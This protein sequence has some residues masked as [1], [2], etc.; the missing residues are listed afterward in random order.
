M[1]HQ[2]LLFG[3][4]ATAVTDQSHTD[5]APALWDGKCFYPQADAGF[6]LETYPGRWYQLAGTLARFTAGCKCIS[7]RY[8][9]N[10]DGSL[11]VNNTCQRGDKQTFIEGKAVAADAA[12]GKAGVLR[13]RF[14]G[15]PPLSCDGP[16]YIVQEYTG[17]IAIVQSANFSNLFILSRE[18]HIQEES[19]NTWIDR[20]VKLGT[21]RQDIVKTDQEDCK[22]DF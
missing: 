20:A 8:D 7:A 15:Q 4:G 10:D 3:L 12:Y 9:I 6:K 16:N 11:Y 22:N 13:V 18:Q 17:A 1:K 2:K 21:P 19:L 5:V 14:P